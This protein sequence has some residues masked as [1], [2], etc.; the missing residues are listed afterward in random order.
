MLLICD[1]NV[2]EVECPACHAP[3]G[4]WCGGN[5]ILGPMAHERRIKAKAVQT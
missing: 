1:T 3:V 4:V 2:V 5:R